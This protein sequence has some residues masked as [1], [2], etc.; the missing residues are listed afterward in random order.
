LAQRRFLVTTILLICCLALIGCVTGIGADQQGNPVSQINELGQ[1]TVSFIDVG[2]GDSILIQTS[3]GQSML[4]DGGER[5]QGEKLVEY[6]QKQGIDQIDVMVGT[7][8][9]SDHIGG[10]IAVLENFQVEK[11][12]LPKVTHSSST[13]KDLLTAIKNQGLKI[14]TAQAGAAIPIEGV[15]ASFIAPVRDRYD[16]L[17]NY[18]AVVKLV[19]GNISFLFCG[20]AEEESEQDILSSSR[21]DLKCQVLKVGH[22][23]SST[24]TSDPFLNAVKPQYAIIMCGAGNDYG[25]PHQEIIEKLKQAGA[26]IY[27][28]DE[29]GNIVFSSDGNSLKVENE[30]AS[31]MPDKGFNQADTGEDSYYIGNKNSKK[32]HRL[33][34]ESLPAEHNQVNLKSRAE[35]LEAGYSPCS[36]CQP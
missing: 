9:H 4:I 8:P 10:L 3:L 13:F 12:Y 15:D 26:T 35:A 14:N 17:N 27:R 11:I 7:H 2:Q 1:L 6:L 16:S 21:G 24:S 19:Y 25:H 18:S 23:G 30:K 28:S 29:N 36:I 33:E 32:F 34:C 31:T 5:N 22:H 20:D